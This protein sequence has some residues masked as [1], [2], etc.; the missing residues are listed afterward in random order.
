MPLLEMKMIFDDI[1]VI[2]CRLGLC[3]VVIKEKHNESIFVRVYK[4]RTQRHNRSARPD[5]PS[6]TLANC[7]NTIGDLFTELGM[8]I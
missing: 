1:E 7:L 3:A 8:R 2:L 5:S 6:F 4:P